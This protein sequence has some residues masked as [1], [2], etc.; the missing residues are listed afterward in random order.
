MFKWM[1][2]LGIVLGSLFCLMYF[3]FLVSES[4]DPI[5]AV[6]FGMPFIAWPVIA[7]KWTKTGALAMIITGIITA[8]LFLISSLF[9]DVTAGTAGFLVLA[10][11]PSIIIGGL[12]LYYW[13]LEGV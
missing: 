6:I 7:W 5:L 2:Y 3:I 11:L 10:L 12:L 8:W 1:K 13:H 4:N 9:M